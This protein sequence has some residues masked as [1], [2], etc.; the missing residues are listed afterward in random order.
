M[1]F[2]HVVD[3]NAVPLGPFTTAA[4]TKAWGLA[5][6]FDGDSLGSM[7]SIVK[8]GKN[9]GQCCQVKFPK[10]LNGSAIQEYQMFRDASGVVVHLEFDYMFLPGFDL[11]TDVG[12][13]GPGI[14]WGP[15]S[16]VGGGVYV[17]L[18]WQRAGASFKGS[19]SFTVQ[20]QDGHGIEYNSPPLGV[21]NFSNGLNIG[22]WYHWKLSLDGRPGGFASAELDGKLQAKYL[23]NGSWPIHANDTVMFDSF[24]HYGGGGPGPL[25]DSFA[26]Q[27]NI[28]YYSDP[29]PPSSA[30]PPIVSQNMLVGS[31]LRNN[32]PSSGPAGS[33]AG[34]APQGAV[35][36]DQKTGNIYYNR[37]SVGNPQWML[38]GI[39]S[40]EALAEVSK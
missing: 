11:V 19:L 28:S 4:K 40:P 31:L 3:F 6:A 14:C 33:Y 38:L 25:V 7:Y 22:Q 37:G 13:L 32:P 8:G 21:Q 39:A 18:I 16:G 30:L 10:G 1:G 36:I 5:P 34:E 9:G 27:D 12:K 2:N 35:V 20:N 17:F 15:R 24:H 23:N 29:E 26:L